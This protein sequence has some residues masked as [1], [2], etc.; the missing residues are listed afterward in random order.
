MV[1]G[2]RSSAIRPMDILLDEWPS[3]ILAEAGHFGGDGVV[4]QE[5][6]R[7]QAQVLSS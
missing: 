5:S 3:P 2:F 1:V 7:S 6:W 4:C